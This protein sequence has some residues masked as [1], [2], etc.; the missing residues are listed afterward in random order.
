V[1]SLRRRAG[2]PLLERVDLRVDLRVRQVRG[3]RAERLTGQP[4]PRVV[5]RTGVALRHVREALA[6]ASLRR[7]QLQGGEFH[8][9]CRVR[10]SELGP[11]S[12]VAASG[13]GRW[14]AGSLRGCPGLSG[15]ATWSGSVP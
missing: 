3:R 9:E 5:E 6:L 10:L 13:C 12:R 8:A 2:E 14:G 1:P 15:S 11:V 4:D 7:R